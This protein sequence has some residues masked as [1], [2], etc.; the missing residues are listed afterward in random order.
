MNEIYAKLNGEVNQA[1]DSAHIPD[2]TEV[3]ELVDRSSTLSLSLNELASLFKIS[4]GNQGKEQ[5][6]N[7]RSLV[8][9]KFLRGK[10]PLRHISPIYISSHCIETC[11][12]CG[13]SVNRRGVDR[14]RLNLSELETEVMAVIAEGSHAIELVLATDPFFSPEVLEKYISK[15]KSLLDKHNGGVALLCSDYF[16]KEDYKRLKDAGL[17][18]IVQWDE[19]LDVKK[20]R[21]WHHKSPRKSNFEQRINT[22]DIALSCGLET[23]TGCLFGLGNYKYD[24]LMQIAKARQLQ[25]KHNKFPFVFGVP[26]LKPINGKNVHMKDEL[27]DSEYEL[28]LMV[29]KLSE[30]SVGRWLQTRE[31]MALNQRNY[32]DNDVCTYRCGNVVPGGYSVNKNCGGTQFKVAEM[33]RGSFEEGIKSVGL[34]VCYDWTGGIK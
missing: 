17:W 1:L 28:A 22:H 24:V 32:L 7:L 2:S 18:G 23:A 29:Y 26:R 12:Y 31:S 27:T 13:Y 33:T 9:S 6:E 21:K 19:T 15:T 8:H 25:Q 34:S 14:T 3:E 20:Y 5:I 10:K 11:G 4:N 16:D 30:P